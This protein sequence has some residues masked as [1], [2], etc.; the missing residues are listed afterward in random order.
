MHYSERIIEEYESEESSKYIYKLKSEN[1]TEYYKVLDYFR[2]KANWLVYSLSSDDPLN[3]LITELKKEITN[4]SNTRFYSEE[5][6]YQ[7]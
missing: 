5:E 1:N 3:T 7:R 2:K 4:K 6:S